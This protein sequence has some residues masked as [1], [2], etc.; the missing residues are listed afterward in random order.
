MHGVRNRSWSPQRN[1]MAIAVLALCGWNAQALTLGRFQVISGT[2]EPLRAEVDII[3]YT[4]QELQGLNARIA[5]QASFQ[6]AGMEYNPGLAGVTTRIAQRSNGRPYISLSGQT[7]LRDNFID[8]ILE[9]EWATGRVVK[10][11]ALLLNAGANAPVAAPSGAVQ[12]QTSRTAVSPAPVAANSGMSA[13][14]SSPVPAAPVRA[15]DDLKPASVELNARQVPVYRFDPPSAPATR[16]VV[17]PAAEARTGQRPSR[18]A[19]A[20][21][22][23]EPGTITV[24]AGDTLSQIALA[25]LPPNV[26][27]DQMMLAIQQANPEAFIETNVNLVK[28]GAVLQIPDAEQA[29]SISRDEARRQVVAQTRAFIEYSRRIAQ[30]PLKVAGPAS[31]REVTGKVETEPAVPPKPAASPDTLTLSKGTVAAAASEEARMASEKEARD[32]DAQV[33]AVTKNLE[34]LQA[35]AK[36][37]APA[38]SEAPGLPPLPMSAPTTEASQPQSASGAGEAPRTQP[39]AAFLDQLANDRNTQIWAGALV[40]AVG[41]IAYW[42]S[43]RRRESDEDSFLPDYDDGVQTPGYGTPMPGVNNPIPPQMANLDLNLDPAVP[44][45]GVGGVAQ[46]GHAPMGTPVGGAVSQGYE[47]DLSKLNLASQ[48]LAKGEHDLAR[49]LLSSVLQSGAPELR[50]RA[51]QMLSQL[52]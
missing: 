30:N 45:G 52:P 7:P 1:L 28:A 22:V 40:L 23:Q 49:A 27:L 47:T 43:R 33:A 9:A 26:S 4:P 38:A 51:Q 29:A 44:A 31:G 13:P 36:G 41:F 25:H 24:Q 12:P 15:T 17:A 11:Y 21:A 20:R 6:A 50:S 10:N 8:L 5:P 39:S 48:L 2:G 16:A 14:V 18:K 32:T 34:D 3:E 37:Q 42:M 46:P 19:S 35:L